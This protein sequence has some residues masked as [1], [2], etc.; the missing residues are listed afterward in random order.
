MLAV[1]ITR[2]STAPPHTAV[3]VVV[4][5]EVVDVVETDDTV[6]SVTVVVDELEVVELVHA[7]HLT[8][9]KSRTVPEVKESWL[10]QYTN[11]KV[12][13]TSGSGKLLQTGVVVVLVALDEVVEDDVEDDAVDVFELTVLLVVTELVV[14]VTVDQVVEVMVL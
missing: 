12:L 5:R 13:H 8:G 11:G 3:P 14:E 4:E 1:Q 7:P 10:S 6:L 9:H 2:G